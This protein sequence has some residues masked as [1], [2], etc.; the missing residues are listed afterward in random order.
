MSQAE[1]PR[2]ST[3]QHD[4]LCLGIEVLGL[5]I[6]ADSLR[7]IEIHLS[8]VQK[9]RSKMNLISIAN[10]R[11]LITHHALDSLA[12]L[13]LI[14]ESQRVLDFGTGAGF[15]GMLLAAAKPGISFSLLDSRT[16]RI[17]FLRLVNAQA[18]LKNVT[19]ISARV[20]AFSPG[21]GF[22]PENSLIS[23]YSDVHAPMKFDTLIARAVASLD[24]L[25]EMTSPLRLSGQRLV[26]MKGQYP[27]E[28]LEVLDKLYSDKFVSVSVELLDVPFL[29][30][31][32]HAIIIEFR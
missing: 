16:R 20:E 13:P 29:D 4:L 17:E 9:W 24:Q 27:G 28:E 18:R 26:A 22:E 1:S 8:L 14:E 32:R 5:D 21:D 25:V 11:D 12:L 15:P 6:S 10:E 31:E 30:A 3:A 2:I 23:P 19:F 7:A